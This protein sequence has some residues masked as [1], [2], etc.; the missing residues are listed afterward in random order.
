VRKVLIGSA[1]C[2]DQAVIALRYMGLTILAALI[3][4]GLYAEGGTVSPTQVQNVFQRDFAYFCNIMRDAHPGIY[5]T[6][7]DFDKQ[8]DMMMDELADVADTLQFEAKLRIFTHHFQDGHTGVASYSNQSPCTYPIGLWWH[9]SGWYL[10]MIPNTYQADIGC[11]VLSINGMD[12]DK[13]MN[14]LMQLTTGEN[15]YWF[16]WQASYLLRNSA[17]LRALRLDSPDGALHIVIEKDGSKKELV[18]NEAEK[19]SLWMNQKTGITAQCKDDYWG[20]ALPD[21]KVYYLQFNAMTDFTEHADPPF[22][23]WIS[24]LEESFAEIDSL[25]IE[26]LVVDLRNNGGGNSSM[27]D[28]LLAFCALPDSLY[29]YGAEMRISDLSLKEFNMDLPT[30]KQAIAAETGDEV[31]ET[32]LPFTYRFNQGRPRKIP[33]LELE[34]TALNG[35]TLSTEKKFHGRLILLTGCHTFSSALMLATLCQDNGLATIYGSPTGGKPSSYGEGVG[36]NL[37]ETGIRCR[38]SVKHFVRPDSS[39]DPS[40]SLYPDVNVPETPE[41]YFSTHDTIWEN[42]LEDIAK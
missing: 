30:L 15:I 12:A 22:S 6:F 5:D 3:V 25:G 38:V 10:E 35:K 31:T 40:D 41:E 27:G 13:F 37:P 17:N 34:R 16:R 4:T 32:T 33:A 20:Q 18:L 28:I 19:H 8:A 29:H 2:R 21:K 7:P 23:G 14:T 42:V 1:F 39:K 11:K 24:F 9:E 36:F 26:N